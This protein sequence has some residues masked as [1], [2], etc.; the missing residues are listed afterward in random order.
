MVLTCTFAANE[1]PASILLQYLIQDYSHA[2]HLIL[3]T[4]DS[5]GE[6]LWVK[7]AEPGR[8]TEIRALSGHL[9]VQHLLEMILFRKV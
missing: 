5:G 7:V 3:I 2:L 6:L 1:I 8:L 9:E 4:L